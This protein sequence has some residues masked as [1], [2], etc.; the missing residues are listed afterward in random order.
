M[1]SSLVPYKLY[2]VLMGP[3]RIDQYIEDE[4]C[5]KQRALLG[6]F[7]S[8]YSSVSRDVR[9][10]VSFFQHRKWPL[11]HER[12]RVTQKSPSGVIHQ[13]LCLERA[14]H[15]GYLLIG[16]RCVFMHFLMDPDIFWAGTGSDFGVQGQGYMVII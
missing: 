7:S 8:R 9:H 11:A 3:S 1:P 6:V 15:A 4:P 5:A 16:L 10:A 2:A 13:K 12:P 14:Q